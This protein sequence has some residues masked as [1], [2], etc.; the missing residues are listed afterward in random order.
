MI[1]AHLKFSTVYVVALIINNVFLIN[2]SETSFQI[3]FRVKIACAKYLLIYVIWVF[4]KRF[5][6][7]DLIIKFMHI[8]FAKQT[9]FNLYLKDRSFMNYYFCIM[10][11]KMFFYD[12]FVARTKCFFMIFFLWYFCGTNLCGHSS[13]VDKKYKKINKCKLWFFI[14]SFLCYFYR[15]F[16]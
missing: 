5:S 6:L 9:A 10:K 12:I 1:S 2:Y 4:S 7:S 14:I 16:H 15:K 13:C 11:Y 3:W 8:K